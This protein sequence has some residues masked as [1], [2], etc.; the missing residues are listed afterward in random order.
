MKLAGVLM[1]LM[2]LRN[3]FTWKQDNKDNAALQVSYHN[4]N[5]ILNFNWDYEISSKI[6]GSTEYMTS[7]TSEEQK[8]KMERKCAPSYGYQRYR[9]NLK[10]T[11]GRHKSLGKI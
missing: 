4:F 7:T 6:L 9:E 3:D 10:R 8:E 2:A 1:S 11:Q 5:L